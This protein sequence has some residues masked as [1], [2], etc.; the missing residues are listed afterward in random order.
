VIVFAL[1]CPGVGCWLA[2][3]PAATPET[4]RP[5][6][7]AL[8]PGRSL[9]THFSVHGLVDD[10]CKKAASLWTGRKEL[11]I[12]TAVR[13]HVTVDTWENNICALCIKDE[14]ALS[15]WHA[16]MTGNDAQ[17]LPEIYPAVMWSQD[18]ERSGKPATAEPIPDRAGQTRR[19]AHA[20]G[21]DQVP[22]HGRGGLAHADRL[23]I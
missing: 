9:L 21:T 8:G 13:T 5:A 22:A 20:P 19:R 17:H 12:V 2:G 15:T 16:A 10:L 11:G 23:D 7:S 6:C 18:R 3:T 4:I 14:G 1:R